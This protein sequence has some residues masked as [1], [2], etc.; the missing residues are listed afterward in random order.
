M[1][2][3][4]EKSL[5]FAATCG[6]GTESMVAEEVTSFGGRDM[7]SGK[8][9]V[10]WRGSLESGY[11]ACLWSRFASRVFLELH[12]FTITDQDSIYHGAR[13]IDWDNHFDPQTTF[14]VDCTVT[15]DTV[16]SIHSRFAALRVKDGLVDQFRERF[17]ERPSVDAERPGVR[18]HLLVRNTTAILS[19]DLSGDSLHKRGYRVENS[20][21]PLKENLAAAIVQVSGW[22]QMQKSGASLV[23]P[24][25][26]SGT[27]LIEA[28][29]M[30]GDS[31]P[32]LFRKYFG[33]MGWKGHDKNI[34]S[35]LVDEAMAREEAGTNQVWPVIVGYDA[36]H[37]AVR[38]ARM[39]VK[40]AGLDDRIRIERAE[41]AQLPSPPEKGLV[42]S[43]LPFGERLSETEE[44]SWLYR[45]LGR[46]MRERFSGW[47]LA[48][49]ISNPDLTDSF[50][51][52]WEE[53]FRLYNGPLHCRVLTTLV[54]PP[55]EQDFRW[56]M[57]GW[58][59][60]G[61]GADF[62]NRLKK[63]LKKMLKWS[64]K[65]QISCYRVYDRDLLE[66][67][68]SIDI[69]EKWVHVQE[70]AP[71]VSV[72]AESA[73]AR[74]QLVLRCVREILGIRADRVFIKTRER[75]RGKQQ[76]QQKS[77][78]KK[79]VEVR[80]GSCSYLANFTDYLDTGVFLDH[81]PIRMRIHEEAV[82]KRFLNLFGY[83]GTATVQAAAGGAV[84]TTT[85][86]LSTT[87]CRWAKM[88]LA[89]NGFAFERNR[90]ISADCMVW[91]AEER[92][93]YDL[94]FVD[95]P[96]FSNTKKERRVFDLQ[97]D[98]YN[99]LT[100]AMA[101]LADNGLLIFSTNFRKF[102][103]DSRL[104]EEYQVSDISRASIPFD[105]ERN[106]KIHMCWEF[107]KNEV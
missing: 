84:S 86:D 94:I 59:P 51:L 14:A 26:G 33:F 48:V 101:R 96:T 65:E 88:N 72:K 70:Y 28:A 105:F 71:P 75:Q 73:A 99:L 47:R 104:R 44:V 66:Y 4:N 60:E 93:E 12:T 82:N 36:D 78:R 34:W 10:S 31:A 20:L 106:R 81:R 27:L 21:A 45:A 58:V 9:V 85:V 50:N 87:Y 43:N 38:A 102:E 18:V 49:F 46:I 98:H 53:K 64:V 2:L 69:Y 15:G 107:R 3:E 80:E 5:V 61:D 74:F 55:E 29:L 83:T 7:E 35:R 42:L 52:Q 32:G 1:T 79:M 56:Q 11:R 62:A 39:N 68:V 22:P 95:P 103:L 77:A 30:F 67:N 6:A 92:G 19:L 24:M 37:L 63:N 25:C 57:T 17:G 54:P 89:L 13:Q 8:G 40:R 90:V 76:Y 41:L 23:D 91:L 16:E 97:R 100:L